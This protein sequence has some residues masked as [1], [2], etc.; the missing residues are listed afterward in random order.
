MVAGAGVALGAAVLTVRP[1][2]RAN[3]RWLLDDPRLFQAL[4]DSAAEVAREREEARLLA[5]QRRHYADLLT[6][7]ALP[8]A[9]IGVSGRGALVEF[10]DYNCMPC[11]Q[12]DRVT[13]S[14]A[15]ALD[16]PVVYVPVALNEGASEIAA[17]VALTVHSKR[18]DMFPAFH[19][20]AMVAPP[21]IGLEAFQSLLDGL[22]VKDL[23]LQDLISSP[24]VLARRRR[25]EAFFRATGALGLPAVLVGGALSQGLVDRAWLASQWRTFY[26]A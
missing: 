23:F 19:A 2:L 21:E 18:P 4:Q 7:G 22:G 16:A 3:A 12:Q 15:A 8:G 11:R 20:R 5:L 6:P 17:R 14:T 25:C 9:G 13:T 1:V 26:S 10:V 24:Q